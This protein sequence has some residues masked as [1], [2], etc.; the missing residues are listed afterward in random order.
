M[1][2]QQQQQQQ[3]YSSANNNNNDDDGTNNNNK[4]SSMAHSEPDPKRQRMD[5]DWRTTPF[6]PVT[7]VDELRVFVVA[8]I[9][10]FLGEEE[11]SFIDFICQQVQTPGKTPEQVLPDLQ[12]VLEED[13][14]IFLESLW[15]KV[16]ELGS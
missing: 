4:G 7:A 5:E 11:D 6:Q 12:D 16:Q 15:R 8:Q 13:A 10:H 14:P 9:Q 1:T 2:Q 3:S